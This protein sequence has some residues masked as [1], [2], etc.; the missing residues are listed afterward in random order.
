[1]QSCRANTPY[2]APR[3]MRQHS[4]DKSSPSAEG[5]CHGRGGSA[6]RKISQNNLARTGDPWLRRAPSKIGAGAP[7]GLSRPGRLGQEVAR[8]FSRTH[9]APVGMGSAPRIGHTRPNIN[10]QQR[11]IPL[12]KQNAK[13]KA[14][15]S[16]AQ[17]CAF[18]DA[19][20]QIRSKTTDTTTQARKGG[21]RPPVGGFHVLTGRRGHGDFQWVEITNAR[22]QEQAG[23]D[24]LGIAIGC[25]L[26]RRNSPSPP[27]DCAYES[28]APTGMPSAVSQDRRRRWQSGVRCNL[29]SLSANRR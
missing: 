2:G 20:Q 15:A 16:P 7:I 5:G 26:C 22:A 6:S 9:F 27:S 14:K 21:H 3:A 25:E 4:H 19:W 10:Q 11:T 13:T 18:D 17:V 29:L 23:L 24:P 8:R 28:R 12:T 1:M